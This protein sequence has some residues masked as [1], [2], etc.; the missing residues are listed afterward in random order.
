MTYKLAKEKSSRKRRRQTG[1]SFCAAAKVTNLR[2]RTWGP[3]HSGT[4]GPS[5]CPAL[6]ET[7]LRHTT[8]KRPQNVSTV[9]AILRS[10]CQE[11]VERKQDQ[12]HSTI[13]GGLHSLYKMAW[14]LFSKGAVPTPLSN[15]YNYMVKLQ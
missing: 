12:G 5:G 4:R 10:F 9:R 6:F 1:S 14:T 13:S 15:S 2:H 8:E 3:G 11:R 7:V